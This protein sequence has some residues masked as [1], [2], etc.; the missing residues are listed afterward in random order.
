MNKT[1]AIV[2]RGKF[3]REVEQFIEQH[4][5]IAN[6]TTVLVAVSGGPDSVAL[7][8]YLSGERQKRN[9]DVIA[10]TVNHQLR[11]DAYKDIIYVEQL[12]ETL[13]V[14]CV[15]TEID[16]KAHKT[17][18]QISTQVAARELRYQIGRAHV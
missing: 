5:L 2:E 12:C 17:K 3:V 16:V 7:L 14:K 18:R 8:H 4:S 13:N 11:E 1:I 9:I 15:K 6:D 10:L